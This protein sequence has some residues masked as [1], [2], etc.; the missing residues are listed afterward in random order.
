MIA[1]KALFVVWGLGFYGALVMA[2][3]QCWR[4]R[5]PE[6][7]VIG[8]FLSVIA[9]LIPLAVLEVLRHDPRR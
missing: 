6:S 7:Y 8:T 1:T 3:I 2:I 5:G 4:E 9:V